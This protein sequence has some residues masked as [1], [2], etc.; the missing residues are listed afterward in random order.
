MMLLLPLPL[1]TPRL[2]NCVFD[3][4]V[5]PVFLFDLFVNPVFLFYLNVYKFSGIDNLGF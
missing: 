4:F 2:C 3:L 5:I 1:R